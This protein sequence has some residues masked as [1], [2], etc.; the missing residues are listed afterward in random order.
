MPATTE[1]QLFKLT[2]N[3]LGDGT[4]LLDTYDIYVRVPGR[5]F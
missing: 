3:V 1:D 5:S 4:V 2:L